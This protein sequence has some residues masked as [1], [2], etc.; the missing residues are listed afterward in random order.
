M[1][2]PSPFSQ[3]LS[4]TRLLYSSFRKRCL[5][6][7]CSPF[8]GASAATFRSRL[9]SSY[10]H[11]ERGGERA[12]KAFLEYKFLGYVPLDVGNGNHQ[13][14]QKLAGAGIRFHF[15]RRKFIMPALAA[16]SASTPMRRGVGLWS[17]MRAPLR[18]ELS[19]CRNH[20]S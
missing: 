18:V 3:N 13:A 5:P 9:F 12:G 8:L 11:I 10:I 20:K 19:A 17:H 14:D 7:S 15:R 6:R 2:A 1:P 16:A 4:K